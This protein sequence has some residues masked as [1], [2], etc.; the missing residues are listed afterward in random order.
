MIARVTEIGPLGIWVSG[1]VLMVGRGAP[2]AIFPATVLLQ[3][4][5][6]TEMRRMRRLVA[7][8][9]WMTSTRSDECEHP[10]FVLCSRRLNNSGLR[11]FVSVLLCKSGMPQ[12][13]RPCGTFARNSRSP[14]FAFD[15]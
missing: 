9:D 1:G 12:V 11:K 15:Q 5:I 2:S 4:T 14:T 6:H 3:A 8:A 7:D 13:Q 10:Q